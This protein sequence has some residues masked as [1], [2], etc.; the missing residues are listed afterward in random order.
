MKQ[1]TTPKSELVSLPKATITKVE[2]LAINQSTVLATIVYLPNTI[3]TLPETIPNVSYYIAVTLLDSFN[4]AKRYMYPNLI[5]TRQIVFSTKQQQGP[6]CFGPHQLITTKET[7]SVSDVICQCQNDDNG[8]SVTFGPQCQFYYHAPTTTSQHPQQPQHVHP[9]QEYTIT[10]GS[11]DQYVTIA[12]Y[13]GLTIDFAFGEVDLQ[14]YQDITITP[15][16][17]SINIADYIHRVTEWVPFQRNAVNNKLS[18]QHLTTI[19]QQST[20]QLSSTTTKPFT[21]VPLFRVNGVQVPTFPNTALQLIVDYNQCE[22]VFGKFKQ[23]CSHPSSICQVD[24]SPETID[25]IE[26]AWVC[27]FGAINDIIDPTNVNS[28]CKYQFNITPNVI[29]GGVNQQQQQEQP[30]RVYF[31]PQQVIKV[32]YDE[33]LPETIQFK[34]TIEAINQPNGP[35]GPE[36]INDG[37][38]TIDRNNHLISFSMPN[39][40]IG[41]VEY[42]LN[43]TPHI[44]VIDGQTTTVENYQ[45]IKLRGNFIT[46]LSTSCAM[47]DMAHQYDKYCSTEGTVSCNLDSFSQPCQCKGGFYGRNCAI[48][49]TNVEDEK[50]VENNIVVFGDEYNTYGYRLR[51]TQETAEQLPMTAMFF[52]QQGDIIINKLITSITLQQQQS[53]NGVVYITPQRPIEF[54]TNNNDYTIVVC[55]HLGTIATMSPSH[56]TTYCTTL[57]RFNTQ[58]TNQREC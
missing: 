28:L 43:I 39:P 12:Q 5:T 10:V 4:V 26:K 33:K 36:V 54:A 22:N 58:S 3:Y 51:Y 19:P 29:T 7:L 21:I 23:H 30:H 16:V 44:T 48:E 6:L 11:V 20:L 17:N 8:N 9:G 46:T 40:T 56:P 45:T 27:Q 47:V 57:S 13:N 1:F 24:S 49:I 52:Y 35:D 14:Y 38:V 41:D 37:V 31:Y 53:L 25:S 2:L 18:L 55:T 32:Q 50:F 15:P 42:F 34:V